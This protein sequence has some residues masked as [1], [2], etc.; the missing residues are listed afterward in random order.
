MGLE[1][2]SRVEDNAMATAQNLSSFVSW[3]W[4]NSSFPDLITT[5]PS[6]KKDDK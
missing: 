5:T 2:S 3:G 4:L 1:A 6:V